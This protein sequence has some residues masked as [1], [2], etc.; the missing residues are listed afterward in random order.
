MGYVPALAVTA[1][2][3]TSHSAAVTLPHAEPPEV[4]GSSVPKRVPSDAVSSLR[5]LTKRAA[6]V[7]SV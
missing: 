2:G 5:E 1:T 4:A 7:A 6:T 3:P